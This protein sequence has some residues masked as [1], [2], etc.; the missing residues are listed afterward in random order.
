MFNLEKTLSFQYGSIIGYIYIIVFVSLFQWGGFTYKFGNWGNIYELLIVFTVLGLLLFGC[1]IFFGIFLIIDY[2]FYNH[3]KNIKTTKNSFYRV[4]QHIGFGI[5]VL[6]SL[7]FFL[8]NIFKPPYIGLIECVIFLI[9]FLCFPNKKSEID[10][11]E[12]GNIID[13]V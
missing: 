3:I 13:E 12:E 6:I 8:L 9:I 10:K 5:Y 1:L 7:P 4:I 2:K 11:L